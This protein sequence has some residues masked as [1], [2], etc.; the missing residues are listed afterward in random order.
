[1]KKGLFI[2][3]VVIIPILFFNSCQKDCE[4]DNPTVYQ[5]WTR[6]VVDADGLEFLAELRI[7]TNNT[8]DFILLE[9]APGHSNTTADLTFEGNLMHVDDND[10][11]GRGTYEYAVSLETLS[12]F[13]KED[14]CDPRV[15]ALQGIWKKK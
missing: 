1:M 11:E 9:D 10:C 7:N 14:D 2:L 15:I 4:T 13:A 5:S 6:K 12:L 3:A 8:F